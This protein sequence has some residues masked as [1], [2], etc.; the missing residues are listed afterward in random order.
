MA[1]I[2][3]SE[4]KIKQLEI[5]LT[6]PEG[7]AFALIGIAK[8]LSRQLD[9]DPGMVQ[10]EMMLGNYEDLLATM[11]HYFGDYIIMYR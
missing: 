7:N 1:I 4:K 2:S 3:K 9:I 6:G 11:E 10:S 5:D 8:N